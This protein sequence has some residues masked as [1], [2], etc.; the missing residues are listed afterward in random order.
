MATPYRVP[1]ISDIVYTR[2]RT[3]TPADIT[4][5]N[6]ISLIEQSR[7]I[8]ER[9]SVRDREEQRYAERV[10]ADEDRFQQQRTDQIAHRNDLKMEREEGRIRD[11]ITDRR[12]RRQGEQR[13][14]I[15]RLTRLA[16]NDDW[17]TYNALVESKY[18]KNNFTSE[19]DRLFW[20][21][22]GKDKKLVYDDQVSSRKDL[23]RY[24]ESEGD[25][26]IL[27]GPNEDISDFITKLSDADRDRYWDWQENKMEQHDKDN[28]NANKGRFETAKIRLTGLINE[29]AELRT[30]QT[31]VWEGEE[32]PAFEVLNELIGEQDTIMNTVFDGNQSSTPGFKI[33]KAPNPL[34][35]KAY[36]WTDPEDQKEAA[37]DWHRWHYGDRSHEASQEKFWDMLTTG[38]IMVTS[39]KKGFISN[40]NPEAHKAEHGDQVI[41]QA[42]VEK[43]VPPSEMEKALNTELDSFV[44]SGMQKRGYGARHFG[45]YNT[46]LINAGE[47]PLS[48]QRRTGRNYVPN[49]HLSR[50]LW[51]VSDFIVKKVNN[52]TKAV[53]KVSSGATEAKRSLL[54]EKAD[55]TRTWGVK[56]METQLEYV[57][58]ALEAIPENNQE[59]RQYRMLRHR[60]RLNIAKI[61]YLEDSSREDY[62]KDLL[63]Q[64]RAVMDLDDKGTIDDFIR[65]LYYSQTSVFEDPFGKGMSPINSAK[66]YPG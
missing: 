47:K 56:K 62:N 55:K 7:S 54:K 34:E 35:I 51:G 42:E 49:Q 18:A 16:D 3:P 60:L 27:T 39:D 28:Y 37:M 22:S 58:G 23:N 6:F 11:E 5:N 19:Q 41:I 32:R 13:Y 52:A 20:A 24:F 44:E 17:S 50:D 38:S 57:E 15:E 29:R 45:S 63:Y 43:A 40:P 12:N 61:A 14:I 64:R 65:R 25:R 8:Q 46:D 30:G 4:L 53:Q 9:Q 10:K 59:H 33:E 2:S 48:N 36:D 1:T 21:Q 31:M 26:S 66:Y